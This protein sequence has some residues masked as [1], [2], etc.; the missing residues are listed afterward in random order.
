ME[1]YFVSEILMWGCLLNILLQLFML[2]YDWKAVA[3]FTSF[4]LYSVN[5]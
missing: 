4:S 2:A 5:N 3:N 1:L